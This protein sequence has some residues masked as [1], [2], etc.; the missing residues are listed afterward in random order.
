M[1]FYIV[2]ADKTLNNK[3]ELIKNN[4]NEWL[5]YSLPSSSSSF[6]F[7]LENLI[8]NK[9]STNLNKK[10][11]K[12]RK[13][14]KIIKNLKL[15]E[16]FNSE[17]KGEEENI[18]KEN[19][20]N[21]LHTRHRKHQNSNI[22]TINY[23]NKQTKYK[24]NEEYPIHILFPLPTNDG[25]RN[26]NPFGI[27]ILKAKPVVDE[28]VEEVYRRQLVPQ[29][30]LRIHFEDSKLSDAH[31]PNVA[32]NQLVNN[33]LDCIIGYAFVYALA[34][35]ARMSPYWRDNDSYGIPVITSVGLTSNLD[36]RRE[37][38]LMTRISSPYKVVKNAVIALF[39]VMNWK[40]SS[41]LF[42][43]Q[44][45][46][47]ANPSIPYGECYLLMASIQPHLYRINRMEHNYFMFNELNY[48]HQRIKENLQK[49][50]IISNGKFLF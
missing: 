14:R 19:S 27:T 38:Q 26:E 11:I 46:D 50:S 28:A 39:S 49:A 6:K 31:G 23:E 15:K 47:A 21:V 48:N 34:P 7:S 32:I 13:R 10:I 45:H 17:E 29:N 24:I 42:H 12:L 37:Y 43:E 3:E 22:T 35:V 20:F 16:F 30:S 2:D 40:R 4:N 9:I 36:N 8:N 1:L 44:R 41:Y 33:T 5:L 25:R 18:K